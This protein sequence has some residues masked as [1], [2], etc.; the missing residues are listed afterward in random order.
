M[1]HP[2]PPLD[3]GGRYDGVIT[4]TYLRVIGKRGTP[5]VACEIAVEIGETK[6]NIEGNIWLTEKA[7]E[8]SQ[9]TLSSLGWDPKAHGLQ[10]E[11]LDA[12]SSSPLVGAKCAII[13]EH[14]VSEKTGRTFMRAGGIYARGRNVLDEPTRKLVADQIRAALTG[15]R[16]GGRMKPGPKPGSAAPPGPKIVEDDLGLGGDDDSMSDVPF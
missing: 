11:D 14:E 15:K 9:K 8:N 6:V 13:V 10:F 2:E 16:R 7:W 4:G 5:C 12:G 3:D 1:N